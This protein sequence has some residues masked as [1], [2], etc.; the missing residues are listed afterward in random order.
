MILRRVPLGIFLTS[1]GIRFLYLYLFGIKIGAD[2]TFYE[3]SSQHIIAAGYNPLALFPT[4]PYYWLYPYI[5]AIFHSNYFL[6]VIFQ[7]ILQSVV[8]V[9]MYRIGTL[10]YGKKAG[11]IAGLIYAFLFEIFQWDTYILTD[12]VFV[13]LLVFV[14]YMLTKGI[15]KIISYHSLILAGGIMAVILLRPTSFPFLVAL[16]VYLLWRLR[17][18][19][20]LIILSL[21]IIGIV[22]VIIAYAIGLFESGH[23]F[24]VTYYLQYFFSL[25]ERGIVIR[26][27]PFYD[28]D[29]AWESGFTASNSITFCNI[30]MHKLAAFWYVTVQDFSWP[31]KLFNILTLI[32][33]YCFAILGYIYSWRNPSKHPI[34]KFTFQV[35]IFFWVF[36]A[37]TEV[38][39]DFRYRVPVLPFVILF[40]SNGFVELWKHLGVSSVQVRELCRYVLVGVVVTMSDI[41]LLNV[42]IRAFHF[43]VY[44][45]TFLGFIVG[46]LVG[47][48]LHSRWTFRYDTTG[49]QVLKISQILLVSGVGLLLTETIMYYGTTTFGWHYNMA[50]ISALVVSVLWAYSCTKWW[51]FRVKYMHV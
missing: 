28:I 20:K 48:F 49:K 29:T 41:G 27:R 11:I 3:L 30:F 14:L 8:A 6:L 15:A 36:Q 1:L 7:V 38:D 18:Y 45:A 47:Y 5:I 21:I 50:K 35:I 23:K 26:D 19:R 12:S 40:A 25:Y 9:L 16:V 24:G 13:G 34:V 17:K 22:G 4:P 2:S 10:L 32:P 31:H 46:S 39:Y 51:V 33:L 43:N 37:L 44:L 42:L